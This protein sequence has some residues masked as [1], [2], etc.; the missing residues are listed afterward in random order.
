MNQLQV[1]ARQAVMGAIDEDRRFS[2]QRLGSCMRQGIEQQGS[3]AGCRVRLGSGGAVEQFIAI[4]GAGFVHDGLTGN[5]GDRG[6]AAKW[7]GM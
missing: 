2:H 5:H 4:H 7:R 3:I 1:T 6:L